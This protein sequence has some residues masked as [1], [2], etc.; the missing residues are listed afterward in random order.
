MD[1]ETI[2]ETYYRRVYHFLLA[3]GRDAAL[4]EELTQETFFSCASGVAGFPR[5]L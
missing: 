3:L 1:F 2:Y 4:A 5:D